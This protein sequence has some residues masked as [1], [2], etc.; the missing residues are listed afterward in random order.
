LQKGLI[1]RDKF[2]VKLGVDFFYH[3]IIVQMVDGVKMAHGS[4]GMV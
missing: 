2:F 3:E 1:K 4:N